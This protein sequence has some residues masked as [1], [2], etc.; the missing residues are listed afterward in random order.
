MMPVAEIEALG[1]T[2]TADWTSAVADRVAAAWGLPPGTARWW[3][4]SAAHVFVLPGSDGKR[5]LRFV[6]ATSRSEASVAAVA[7]LMAALADDGAAVVRPVPA[8][9]GAL[10]ATVG[11]DLGPMHA[12]VVEAAPGEAIDADDLTDGTARAWGEALATL[13][14]DAAGHGEGLPEAFGELDEV[15]A[16][17]ADDEAVVHAAATLAARLSEVPRDSAGFGVV[18]GDP[19]LDNLAWDGGRAT[20]Y[21]FDEAARSWYAADVAFALRD[22]TGP[23]G[24]IEPAFQGRAAAFVAGYR[25][26]RPFTAAEERRLPLFAGVHAVGTLVRIGRA[27]DRPGAPD[28]A[29]EAG[30]AG[31]LADLRLHLADLARA[32]RDLAVAVAARLPAS[33]TGVTTG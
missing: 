29:G 2:V 22:L 16:R 6:P 3:R 23:D 14:R 30:A 5:Y 11:T 20:A 32:Q 27:L 33:P 31:G 28:D 19:E 1:R 17:H 7:R 24:R 4:S 18:H 9:S 21:D 10:V 25:A 15:A 8:A 12:V 13:H 26:V